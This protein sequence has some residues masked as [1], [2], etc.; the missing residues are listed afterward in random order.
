MSTHWKNFY[1]MTLY[2][3]S[4][5]FVEFA[6]QR[7]TTLAIVFFSF[8]ENEKIVGKLNLS[9]AIWSNYNLQFR[10]NQD[11]FAWNTIIRLVTD[12]QEEL[13]KKE[14]I[15]VKIS[16]PVNKIQ[17]LVTLQAIRVTWNVF[18]EKIT[19]Y[20]DSWKQQ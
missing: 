8:G 18:E 7:S 1:H 19:T 16:D 2:L 3:T 4:V 20:C 11:N 17:L 10:F 9:E 13:N 14:K 15:L 12:T 6:Y 5:I